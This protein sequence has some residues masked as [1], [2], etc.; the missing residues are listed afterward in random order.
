MKNSPLLVLSSIYQRQFD[1]LQ[2]QSLPS[3]PA[4]AFI[5]IVRGRGLLGL[6]ESTSHIEPLQVWFILPGMKIRIESYAEPIRYFLLFVRGMTL[7][8]PVRSAQEN[9][10]KPLS[11][12]LIPLR[13][14]GESYDRIMRLYDVIRSPSATRLEANVLFQEWLGH[15]LRLV[16]AENDEEFLGPKDGIQHSIDYIHRNFH[17]K[18]ALGQLA[19]LAGFTPTSYSR[20]FKKLMGVSPIEYLTSCRVHYAK[21][22]LLSTHQTV[23]QVS[24]ACG[25]GNEFYFSRVFKQEVGISPAYYRRRREI[26]V[27][28]VS[29][30][31]VN[32]TLESLGVQPVY[33]ANWRPV[34]TAGREEHESDMD[35]RFERLQQAR[36]ELIIGDSY[37]LPYLERLQRIAPTYILDYSSD[38]RAICRQIAELVGREQEAERC[39][40]LADNKVDAARE[41]LLR[42]FGNE[43]VTIMRVV[44]KLIRIQGINQHPL[45]V[46]IYDEL[47][48]K[49]GFY[50][51]VDHM[52]VE[53]SPDKYPDLETD[54]LL[55]QQKFHFP[56]DEF[57]FRS[58][59]KMEQWH[60]M[61]AVSQGKVHYIDNWFGMSWSSSGRIRII[62]EL[63]AL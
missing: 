30:L 15:M 35:L 18:L 59:Q 7:Y 41:I 42:R 51:P 22:L 49:P 53:F 20:E 52:N 24:S 27:A 1:R 6:D 13:N 14:D 26:R 50:V 33:S 40:E 43:T 55:I 21:R 25:F 31:R 36:P 19:S 57:V 4:P 5:Y 23:K 48:L 9:A 58:I 29:C 54:H 47:G 60:A 45:N 38:W 16:R 2:S 63:L 44:H 34:K 62:S 10:F 56:D 28:A 46:L 32:D 39:I 8:G 12:G 61:R 17:H 37:H 11:P 3:L